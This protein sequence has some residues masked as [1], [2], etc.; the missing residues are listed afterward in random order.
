MD[1][2][3]SDRVEVLFAP[4]RSRDLN[5]ES[6]DAKMTFWKETIVKALE[7]RQTYKLTLEDLFRGFQ[8]KNKRPIG[9]VTVVLDMRD[10]DKSLVDG[11]EFLRSI[12]ESW[13]EVPWRILKAG[14]AMI[15]SALSPTKTKEAKEKTQYFHLEMLKKRG[16][17]LYEAIEDIGNKYCKKAD[18]A[19]V[20]HDVDTLL[21][22]LKYH[23]NLIDYR[24]IDNEVFIKLKANKNPF[25]DTDVAVIRLEI[26][27]DNLET[28]TAEM[29]HKICEKKVELKNSI[30]KGES[31]CRLRL[32]LK[33]INRMAANVES[34]SKT[35]DNLQ[36]VLAALERAEENA[37]VIPTL[38]DAKKALQGELANQDVLKVDELIN[39]IRELAEKTEDVAEVIRQAGLDESQGT[40]GDDDLED[41]LMEL[42]KDENDKALEKALSELKVANHALPVDTESKSPSRQAETAM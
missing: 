30:R 41:E 16:Q 37:K 34:K 20:D 9:L 2:S 29:D 42:L 5:P 3:D 40:I 32:L 38:V 35:I 7:D 22:Y 4:F 11:K 25:N 33:Q 12:K 6:Y 17:L 36:Q 21:E 8:F 23:E 19:D 39:D 10:N 13:T 31:R 27:I 18:V 1:W 14:T 15:Y 28:T 26:I 24:D